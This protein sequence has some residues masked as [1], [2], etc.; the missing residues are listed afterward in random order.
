MEWS[1]LSVNALA[2]LLA[3]LSMS[4]STLLVMLSPS[5]PLLPGPSAGQPP[6]GWEVESVLPC[7]PSNIGCV[8]LL[9]FKINLSGV[10]VM[11]VPT[12]VAT[13]HL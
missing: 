2:L 7:P 11:F 6:K 12:P 5:S 4:P 3:S 9:L 8:N 10:G 13:C 1:A